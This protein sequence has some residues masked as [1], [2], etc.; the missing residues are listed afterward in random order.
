MNLNEPPRRGENFVTRKITRAAARIKLSLQQELTLGNLDAQRD[1]GYA[2]EY[3]AAMWIALQQDKPD[4]YVLATNE[5]H[6]IRDFLDASFGHVGLDWRDYVQFDERLL[7]P[8][9][10]QLLRGDYSKAK[11]RLGWEPQLRMPGLAALMVDADMQ[12]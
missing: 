7:R 5:V 11:A 6:S 4:D 9:E 1:W 10:G 3:V 12:F 2:K 8:T